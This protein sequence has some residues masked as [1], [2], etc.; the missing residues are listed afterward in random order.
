MVGD[1]RQVQHQITVE[2]TTY[3]S[4]ELSVCGHCIQYIPR[5]TKPMLNFEFLV[6]MNRKACLLYSSVLKIEAVYCDYEQDSLLAILFNDGD[7]G[8]LL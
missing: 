8:S 3:V 5:R 1:E 4:Q 6:T 2:R 7:K